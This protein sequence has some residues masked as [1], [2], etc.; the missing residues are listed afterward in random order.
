MFG[1]SDTPLRRI[2][3]WLLRRR[4]LREHRWG[5][6]DLAQRL[7]R[8]RLQ[9]AAILALPPLLLCAWYCFAAW[10]AYLAHETE[11]QAREP[12]AVRLFQLHL[13]DKLTRDWHRLLAPEPQRKS[14][15]PTYG[16]VLSNEKLDQ[17]SRRLPPDDGQPYYVDAQLV[18]GGRAH[19]VQ[20]R[21]RGGK[22]WHYNHPQKS[23]KVRVKDG[24]VFEG[25][26]TFNF[27]NTPESVPFDEKNVLDVAREL[28]LLTPEYF[29]FR[30][31]INKAYTGVYF[32]E[33]QADEGLLRLARRPSGA[34]YSGS[35]SP[36]DGTTGVSTLFKSA[37]NF[38][39]VAQGIHQKLGERKELE[40]LISALSQFS[41]RDF[42]AYAQTH[43]DMD[44]FAEW[45]AL[46]VVFGCN[47]H[48]FSDNHKLYFD[49]Y[50]GRFEPIAWNFR[51][52]K[53]E[54]ELNRTENPIILR[55]KQL[56]GYLAKRNRIAY[57]LAK[58]A[59]SS[60][61][62]RDRTR[63]WLDRLQE[64]QR[65]DPYWDAFQLLPAISPYYALLLRP[66]NRGVQDMA[67]E[68]RLFEMDERQAFLSETFEKNACS[69][70]L[71]TQSSSITSKMSSKEIKVYTSVLDIAVGNHSGYSLEGMELTWPPACSPGHWQL[72]A[73][74]TL[75]G[76]L[77][78]EQDRTVGSAENALD[79]GS[80]GVAM[81]PGEVIQER[82]AQAH[83]G[84]ICTKPESRVYRFF[85]QSP[86]CAPASARLRLRNLVTQSISEVF[87]ATGAHAAPEPLALP[88]CDDRYREEPGQVSPHPWCFT[89]AQSQPIVLGPGPIEIA[90][91]RRFLAEQPVE[92]K[93]DT[94]FKLAPSASLILG[95]VTAHGTESRPIRF[96]ATNGFWGGIAIHGPGTK[97]SE[98]QHVQLLAGTRVTSE[99][100]YWPGMVNLNDT[101]DVRFENVT[102]VAAAQSPA[103]VQVGESRNVVLSQV[104][105]R[106][107]QQSLQVS[108]STGTFERIGAVGAGGTALN[109]SASQITVRDSKFLSF[110]E[111]GICANAQSDVKLQ[112]VAF[113]RG[114]LGMRVHEASN[115]ECNQVL[116]IDDREC[117]QLDNSGGSYTARARVTGHGLFTV[118][119]QQVVENSSR[120]NRPP[121]ELAERLL[122][123]DLIKLRDSV[124][125]ISDWS[126]L[127]NQVDQLV[128]G[129]P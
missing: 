121:L 62:L 71:T 53:H 7:L 43:L 69:V 49:P 27:I 118:G 87:A 50:R 79:L 97:A 17:L 78:L 8:I 9:S 15:L 36:I 52:C 111:V 48:D 99:S 55:L 23:W 117:I 106:G 92:I 61:A 93:P 74:T 84:R 38:T 129:G 88:H 29:P 34:I 126:E 82:T 47:Q 89:V 91:T 70:T 18:Q 1:L 103:A 68:T 115:V 10:A 105:I 102:I 76:T 4:L 112:D 31:L 86:D 63:H 90:Q 42:A 39:K 127:G 60:N 75:D 67:V 100:P 30:L 16:L 95:K 40:E 110:A 116:F 109:V 123:N 73:D 37:E 26:S 21:Y 64:D 98:F 13:H 94:T 32:F 25:L 57:E 101:S 85:V 51:G 22:Y 2:H 128:S 81:Y 28:G 3:D 72:L 66:V 45:D 20:V 125:G 114:H 46:D 41:H 12:F 19:N 33:A 54:P 122:P 5:Q 108:Y 113:I 24:K 35:E 80:A 96:E 65:R 11:V 56:P 124:F 6:P 83:G 120:R 107:A 77:Q 104:D 119:C 44:K 14:A 58:G 59:A